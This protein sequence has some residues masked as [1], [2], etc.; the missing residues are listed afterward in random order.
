M[1]I[2]GSPEIE[3]SEEDKATFEIN[4]SAIKDSALEIIKESTSIPK[5]VGFA[6][7]N[8]DNPVT[9]INYICNN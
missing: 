9:L 4:V 1:T 5:E 7:R 8:F 3:V 2:S 6:L